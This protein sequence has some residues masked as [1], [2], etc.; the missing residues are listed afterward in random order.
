[1]AEDEKKALKLWFDRKAASSLARQVSKAW[2]EFDSKAFV[3]AAARGINGLEFH[4]RVK[5]FSDALRRYLP[6]EIPRALDILRR[7][8][9]DGTNSGEVMSESWLQWPIGQF[10]ADYAEDEFDAAFDAMIALTQCFTSE[11]AVRPFAEAHQ[12]RVLARLLVL[13]T[14]PSPHVRRWCSEGIRPRLPWGRR[15]RALIV[16]PVPLFPILEALK[17]DPALYVRRSVANNLN[18]IAKD[19]PDTVVALCRRWQENGKAP[20]TRQWIIRHALRSL[21]KNGHPGALG[22]MGVKPVA[23]LQARLSL[24]PRTLV[25][26]RGVTMDLVLSHAEKKERPVVVDYIVHY[27]RQRGRTGEKVFKWTTLELPPHT[28]IRLRKIHPMRT[29]TIRALYPGKH[30]VEIQVNGQRIARG[31]FGLNPA[32]SPSQKNRHEHR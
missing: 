21:V 26:G 27:V 30:T 29:T 28:N 2:P 20:A 15:L 3:A 10:I 5:Q 23:S 22:I 18:D 25:I 32:S 14:H 17:D 31:S 7:G 13:T 6:A 1:M 24:L 4:A 9:P 12:D 11:F 19:H 8:L 16:D